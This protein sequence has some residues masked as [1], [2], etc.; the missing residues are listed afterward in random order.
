MAW[1][2]WIFG[3]LG[4]AMGGPIGGVLGFAMG[5]ALDSTTKKSQTADG[6]TQPGDF[7]ASLLVL[8]AAV[9]KSDDK[10]LKSELEY[11]KTFFIRHFGVART[12]ELMLVLRELLKKELPLEEMCRQIKM[13]LDEPSR[14]QLIHLLFGVSSAD[15]E[16]HKKEVDTISFIASVLNIGKADFESIKAMFYSDTESAY[17]IL[18]VSPSATDDELKK[19]YRSMAAK[20]H[21]DKVHHLGPDFQKDAQEKFKSINEAYEKIKKERGIK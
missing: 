16:V 18:E 1:S 3:T 13:H 19:A 12:K 15:G 11:V 21:P 6:A 9:M 20:H 4:W 2:K 14:L 17:R 7:A 8:C 5:T 10:V